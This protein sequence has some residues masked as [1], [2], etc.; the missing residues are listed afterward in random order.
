M[1]A[2][3]VTALP[4]LLTRLVLTA[5]LLLLTRLLPAAALLLAR[6]RVVLLLLVRL[7]LVRIVHA[8]SSRI[9]RPSNLNAGNSIGLR[10]DK[11]HGA[12]MR[13]ESTSTSKP[14]VV[15]IRHARVYTRL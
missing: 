1:L 5:A 7:L 14:I 11:F 10:R 8:R 13:A 6:T 12:V 9:D 3:L 15:E 4:G 2:T